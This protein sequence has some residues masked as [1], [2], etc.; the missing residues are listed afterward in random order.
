MSGSGGFEHRGVMRRAR[1]LCDL[2]VRVLPVDGAAVLICGKAAEG[3]TLLCAT[4]PMIAQLD[5]LEFVTAE[6]P[7]LQAYRTDV[8]VLEPDLAGASATARWPWFAPEAVASGARAVFAFPLR[9]GAVRFGVFWLY[10]RAPG[11]LAGRDL[12]AVLGIAQTAAAVVLTDAAEHSG[13]QLD[14]HF[15]DS[16]YGQVEIDR[17]LGVIAGQRNSD[18]E[19]ARVLLRGVAYAQ[20]RS[21][22]SVARDVLTHRLTFPPDLG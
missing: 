2:V 8:P 14:A 11:G 18:I 3:S 4:D 22:M 19:Q 1:L 16:P 17:A 21:S 13:E 15:R 7:C 6:G 12:N 20:N 10:R 5:D 9:A